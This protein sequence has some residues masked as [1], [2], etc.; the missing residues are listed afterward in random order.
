MSNAQTCGNEVIDV[1]TH[2]RGVCARGRGHLGYCLTENEKR[3]YKPGE[4]VDPEVY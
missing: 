4:I 1:T 2:T 3:L